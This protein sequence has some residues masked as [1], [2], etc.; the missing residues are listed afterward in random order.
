MLPDFRNN[1]EAFK[2]FTNHHQQRVMNTALG[3]VHNTE[4]AEEITQDVFVEAYNQH[5]KFKGN[6]AV[7][8]WLYRITVNKCIDFL[9]RKKTQKRFAFITSLFNPET[10]EPVHDSGHFVHPGILAE[11]REKAQYLFKAAD[12][13]PAN[14]KTAWV[15]SE[16][17]GLKYQEIAD[18]LNLSVSSVESL[19]FRARQ[20]LRKI[21]GDFYIEGL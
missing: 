10:N 13:L 11:N 16:I 19:I 2:A 18:V 21:L 7:S 14:Q 8:T 20:N 17:E 4:D 6:A 5:E 15:L 9:R 3:M 1:P 12:R